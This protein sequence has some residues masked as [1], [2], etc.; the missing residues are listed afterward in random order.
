MA[1]VRLKAET[2]RAP[3]RAASGRGTGEQPLDFGA[4]SNLSGYLLRRAQLRVFQ[5]FIKSCEGLDIRP[6][7]YSALTLIERNPGR[8]QSEIAGA[9]G[10]KRTNFVVLFN[11]LEARGLAVRGSGANDRRSNA[12]FLTDAGRALMRQLD[13]RVAAHQKRT[14]TDV[15]AADR[16]RFLA[17]LAH[18]GATE[19]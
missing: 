1:P 18:L 3:A 4:L 5:D 10:I 7:Q 16:Q 13:A 8:R 15:P 17:T 14:L 19:T 6:A 12:L 9:L 2:T 11:G